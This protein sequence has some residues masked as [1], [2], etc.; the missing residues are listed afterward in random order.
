[1]SDEVQRLTAIN[2]MLLRELGR[3][4]DEPLTNA[5]W[6]DSVIVTE[7]AIMARRAIAEARK[8]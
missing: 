7:M 1:M 5:S 2:A 4:A 8:L 3:I 6:T